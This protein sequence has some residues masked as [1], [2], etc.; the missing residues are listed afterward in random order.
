MTTPITDL[1]LTDFIAAWRKGDGAAFDSLIE[2]TYAQLQTMAAGRLRGDN[3]LVTLT[4]QDL[5]HE[6][7]TKV[8]ASPPDL[9]NRAHFFATMSLLMRSI[10]V[11]CA[12]AKLTDKRGNGLGHITFTESRMNGMGN[13]AIEIDILALDAALHRLAE[14]DPRSS[15]VLHLTYFAGMKQDDIAQL[16]GVSLPTIE[17]DLRF[18]RAWLQHEL[19]EN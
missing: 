12:R 16:I 7:V 5:L 3:A 1:P 2:A 4:P 11:D 8:M 10:I 13:E 6:A 15:N 19:T 9:N 18:A 14:T 17:R